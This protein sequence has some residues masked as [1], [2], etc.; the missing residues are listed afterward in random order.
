MLGVF[1]LVGL[2]WE[3]FLLAVLLL[4]LLII[5]F[6]IFAFLVE[7]P[8]ILMNQNKTEE[9]LFSLTAIAIMNDRK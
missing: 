9:A 5:Y 3:Y 6:G 7:S 8:Y 4:P 2:R 1:Y